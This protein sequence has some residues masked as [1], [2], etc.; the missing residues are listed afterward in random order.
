MD[1]LQIDKLENILSNNA[2]VLQDL[3]IRVGWRFLSMCVSGLRISDAMLLNDATF[4]DAGDLE[5]TPVKTQRYG[6]KAQVPIVSD[7]QK[8]YLAKTIEQPLPE[9]HSNS[10]RT[11]FNIHLK[12]LCAAAGIPAITSHS[13]RHTMGSL[14]VDAGVQDKSA[15]AMLGVKSERVIRTYMHLKESK[16]KTEAEKLKSIL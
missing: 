9:T 8:R 14:L 13:G 15:M 7:R 2:V 3:T 10:F 16:L 6:N 1:I 4:N 11:T 12:I 5:F